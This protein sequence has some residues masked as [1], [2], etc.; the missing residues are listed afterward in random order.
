[1]DNRYTT[2]KF[3]IINRET[4]VIAELITSGL[5][6]IRKIHLNT[7]FYYQSFYAISMGLERLSKLIVHIEKPDINPYKIGHDLNNLGNFLEINFLSQS[8]EYQIF[9]F[10]N[11]F[12]KGDRYTMIDFLY[13]NDNDRLSK[14]PIYN[15]YN[16]IIKR[17]L[18]VNPPQRLYFIPDLSDVS[19]VLRIKEDL[20]EIRSLTEAM[21]HS[22]LIEHAG[23][24][25]AMYMARVARP[26]IERLQTHDGNSNPFFSEHF[27]YLSLGDGYFLKRKTY[28]G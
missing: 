15:Y 3:C 21:Q 4:Q 13:R 17:I 28:R 7:A 16:N 6:N 19:T 24:Y 11:D 23:K 25:S 2:Q 8:V 10:L 20:S 5:E 9:K 22:Q 27:K 26:F 18:Q 12:A 1:M 14:E